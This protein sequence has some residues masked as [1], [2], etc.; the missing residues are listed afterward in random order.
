MFVISVYR[1]PLPPL[2]MKKREK[3]AIYVSETD[4][5]RG[6]ALYLDQWTWQRETIDGPF[7]QTKNKWCAMWLKSKCFEWIF[8]FS[9]TTI[10]FFFLQKNG[11]LRR[12]KRVELKMISCVRRIV[13]CICTIGENVYNLIKSIWSDVSWSLHRMRREQVRTTLPIAVWDAFT[14]ESMHSCKA[15]KLFLYQVILLLKVILF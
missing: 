12:P 15:N 8:L 2:S 10:D 7:D 6:K 5:K 4:K 3:S 13:V 1:S 11:V 9:L 14:T